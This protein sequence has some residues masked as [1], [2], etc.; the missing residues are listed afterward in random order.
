[1]LKVMSNAREASPQQ[2]FQP[3][4]ARVRVESG[5][6]TGHNQKRLIYLDGSE[7]VLRDSRVVERSSGGARM[8]QK[9]RRSDRGAVGTTSVTN[10]LEDREPTRRAV[11]LRSAA[12][13]S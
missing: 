4:P 13:S 5:A 11:R 6:C 7:D 9:A 8:R 12:A 2:S 10:G 1:M 3:L